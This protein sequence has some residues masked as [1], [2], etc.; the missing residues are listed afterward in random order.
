MREE[1]Y[2][3]RWQKITMAWDE[4]KIKNE[5]SFIVVIPAFTLQVGREEHVF[6]KWNGVD[7]DI[8]TTVFRDEPTYTKMMVD[9]R[10][11][12]WL[13]RWNA[14]RTYF[15]PIFIEG[16]NASASKPYM[17]KLFNSEKDT[18]QSNLKIVLQPM[19]TYPFIAATA[20]EMHVDIVTVKEPY[21]TVA[22]INYF[23]FY[24]AN[25]SKK[26]PGN[27]P[28]A[29]YMAGEMTAKFFKKYIYKPK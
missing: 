15:L 28:A 25:L 1:H 12:L 26:Y 11:Y 19:R 29:F 18:V 9:S 23:T 13:K 4:T 7:S 27:L 24:S 2:S 21:D 20:L 5:K 17:P 3:V 16:Y 6:G 14:E 10:G 22:R 8:L